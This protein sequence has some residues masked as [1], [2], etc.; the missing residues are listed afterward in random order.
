MSRSKTVVISATRFDA[1]S[2]PAKSSL[3]TGQ[4]ET[5]LNR[6][7]IEDFSAPQADYVSLLAIAPSLTGQ[8]VNGPGLSDGNVKN[9]LRGIPDGNFGMSYDGVPFG[10]TNGPTHH[11]ISYFSGLDDRL[12]TGRSWSGQRRHARRIHLRRHHQDVLRALE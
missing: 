1:E 9:T 7:Y 6:P 10:D 3:N 4:P 5:I 12:H 11:S 2:A 8:D